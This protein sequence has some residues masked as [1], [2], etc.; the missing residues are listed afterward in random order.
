MD[1][2]S[3]LVQLGADLT[4]LALSQTATSVSTKVQGIKNSK[5]IERIRSTY[6][7]QTGILLEERAE[8]IRIAQAYKSEL[9]KVQI[10]DKDIEHL[11]NMI[12]V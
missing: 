5:D 9:D 10:S 12:D 3:I 6:D 4:T 7:E 8:A 1:P 2:T 11:H